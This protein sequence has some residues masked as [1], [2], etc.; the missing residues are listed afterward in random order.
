MYIREEENTEKKDD[1][2]AVNMLKK[3]FPSILRVFFIHS[4]SFVSETKTEFN[5]D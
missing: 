3:N 1:A 5:Q 2:R 4:F